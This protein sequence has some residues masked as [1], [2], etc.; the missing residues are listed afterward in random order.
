MNMGMVV[1][2]MVGMRNWDGCERDGGEKKNNI[3]VQLEI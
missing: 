2:E 1:R 3:I